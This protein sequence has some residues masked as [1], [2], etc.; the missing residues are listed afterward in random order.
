MIV[1]ISRIRKRLFVATMVTATHSF[2][3]AERD[4]HDPPGLAAAGGST[5]AFSPL[6]QQIKALIR[7]DCSRANGS[8]ASDSQ[9]V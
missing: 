5:P 3:S 2:T 1:S 6:Y 9:R 8:R 7:T 4:P